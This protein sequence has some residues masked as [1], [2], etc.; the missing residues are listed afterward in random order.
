MKDARSFTLYSWPRR[1]LRRLSGG[2][3]KSLTVKPGRKTQ[4]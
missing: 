3:M 1:K 2:N 4:C